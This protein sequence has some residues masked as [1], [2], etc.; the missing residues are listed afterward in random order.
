MVT[1]RPVRDRVIGDRAVAGHAWIVNS[2]D[3]PEN[4]HGNRH[5]YVASTFDVA[6]DHGLRTALLATKTKFK[7][8][9]N[10]YDGSSGAADAVGTDNGR[11]K[12][13][14][15]LISETDSPALLTALL[16]M[17]KTEPANYAFVHFHDAD[18]AGH[19]HN[20][21]SPEYNAA[22]KAVDGYL[23]AILE[24]VATDPRLRGKTTVIV[25]ADHGGFQSNHFDS[26]NRLNYTIPFY[27]WGAGVASGK[28]LY[29]LNAQTRKDPLDGRPDYSAGP[30]PIRNGDGGNLALSL[31]GLPAIP[32]SLIDQGEDLAVSEKK[33]ASQAGQ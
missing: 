13:D 16:G 32:D 6:H 2:D 1:G 8:Y 31:L 33:T 11:D 27:V 23:G 21:G 26:A 14:F 4:L 10:S 20:W 5:A 3:Q 28:D 19:A 29:A 17:M 9:E 7:I 15:Y 30:Q 22:V 25:S 12:I 18:K 24:L